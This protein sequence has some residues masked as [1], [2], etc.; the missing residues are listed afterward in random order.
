METIASIAVLADSIPLLKKGIVKAASVWS[1]LQVGVRQLIDV[2]EVHF[3]PCCPSWELF[4]CKLL[5]LCPWFF[6]YELQ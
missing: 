6:L 4:F 5:R 1:Q 3:H 2:V